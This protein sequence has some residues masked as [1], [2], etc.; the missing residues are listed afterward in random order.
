MSSVLI[1]VGLIVTAS[2][3]CGVLLA[4]ASLL[5]K[6]PELAERPVDLTQ[7]FLRSVEGGSVGVDEPVGVVELD[8][9]PVRRDHVAPG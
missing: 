7:P 3:L 5:T 1:V 8:E 2:L 9:L 6:A 4:R